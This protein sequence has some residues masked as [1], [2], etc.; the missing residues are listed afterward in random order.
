MPNWVYNKLTVTGTKERLLKFS[1]DIGSK[2]KP[3]D[4]SKIA[5]LVENSWDSRDERDSGEVKK[6]KDQ[7]VYKFQTA[8]GYRPK[9]LQDLSGLYKD[10]SFLIFYVEE[11]PAFVGATCFAK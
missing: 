7:L 8:W 4:Y 1:K 3:F 10:L 11:G 9:L 2:N 6:V 5:T